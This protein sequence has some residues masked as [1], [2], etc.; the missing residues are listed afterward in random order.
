MT[1]THLDICSGIGGFALAALK[2]GIETVGFCECDEFCQRVLRKNFKRIPIYAYIETLPWKRFRNRIW[3]LTAGLPCQPFSVAG[4]QAGCA[5][6]RYLWPHLLAGIRVCRPTWIVLEN[7][8]NFTSMDASVV[9]VGLEKEGY[10]V[11]PPLLIPACAIGSWQRRERA[12]LIACLDRKCS[13]SLCNAQVQGERRKS[14]GDNHRSAQER[15]Q[16]AVQFEPK[17]LRSTN[18]LPHQLDRVRTLGNAID[19]N[20]AAEIFRCI[21]ASET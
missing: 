11:G 2:V 1:Q 7:V 17:L 10:D 20:I 13:K 3:I 21:I 9:M 19:P 14:R 16:F 5:D 8:A 4:R 15:I 18:E 12:W 6:D